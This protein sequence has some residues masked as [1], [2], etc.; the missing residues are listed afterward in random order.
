[1]CGDWVVNIIYET[2]ND[3]R[4]YRNIFTGINNVSLYKKC[5]INK[6]TQVYY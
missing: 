5:G 1:M 2:T 6:Y 4:L 3:S